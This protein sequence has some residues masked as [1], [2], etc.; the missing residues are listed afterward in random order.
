MQSNFDNDGTLQVESRELL[1]IADCQHIIRA[2]GW[3]V[4]YTWLHDERLTET[5]YARMREFKRALEFIVHMYL[6][7]RP[8]LQQWFC[9]GLLHIVNQFADEGYLTRYAVYTTEESKRGC[10]VVFWPIQLPHDNKFTLPTRLDDLIQQNFVRRSSH[11]G[12]QTC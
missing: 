11:P 6:H 1:T 3:C 9:E 12:E 5:L 10:F 8:D 4:T 2:H 7:V